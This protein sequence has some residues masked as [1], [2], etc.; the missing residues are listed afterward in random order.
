VRR[1][2]D[3]RVAKCVDGKPLPAVGRYQPDRRPTDP[4]YARGL[5]EAVVTAVDSGC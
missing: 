4:E 1:V 5:Q 3:E 2:L